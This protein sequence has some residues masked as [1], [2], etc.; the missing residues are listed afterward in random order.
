MLKGNTK[1]ELTNIHTGKKEVIEKHNT[2]TNAISK[3]LEYYTATGA[4]IY[5]SSSGHPFL[6]LSTVGL[7]GIYLSSEILDE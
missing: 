3:L 6:P 2:F 7:S 5:Y 4:N 1:I